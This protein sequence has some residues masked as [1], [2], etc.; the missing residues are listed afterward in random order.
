VKLRKAAIGSDDTAW[1]GDVYKVLWMIRTFH[2]NMTVRTF[3]KNQ[4]Q[5]LVYYSGAKKASVSSATLNEI[6]NLSYIDTLTR[7][8]EYNLGDEDEILQECVATIK[9]RAAELRS[10]T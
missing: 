6:A 5:A 2:N 8:T 9:Q 10:G 4:P 7:R 1:Q 3:R